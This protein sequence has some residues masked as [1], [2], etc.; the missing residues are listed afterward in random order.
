MM[1]FFP[2]I[3]VNY[4]S[5]RDNLLLDKRLPNPFP[6]RPASA[7]SSNPPL[8]LLGR[9]K[10]RKKLYDIITKAATTD[11]R[12]L[13]II[14]GETGMGKSALTSFIFSEITK[15]TFPSQNQGL[16][17][18]SA[19]IEA[20]GEAN[21]FRLGSFY[22]Q[23]IKSLDKHGQLGTIVAKVI[24][25]IG[26]IIYETDHEEFL[27]L[28]NDWNIN[29]GLDSIFEHI[30]NYSTAAQFY[31]NLLAGVSVFYTQIK[32]EWKSIDSSFLRVL[33]LSQF[34]TKNRLNAIESLITG[35]SFDSFAVSTDAEARDLINTFMD[36]L[37]TLNQNTAFVLF[38]D[39]LEELFTIQTPEKISIQIFTLLLT[40]R[41]IPKLS[42][43]LSGNNQAFKYLLDNLEE[44]PRNQIEQWQIFLYL[45]KLEGS[46]VCSIIYQLLLEFWKAQNMTPD[47]KAPF[48][49]FSEK[50]IE[51]I[52][53]KNDRNLRSTLINFHDIVSKFRDDEKVEDLTD[54]IKAIASL[55][56]IK[57]PRFIP[58]QIQKDFYNYLISNKIQ[59][60][61]RAQ[62]PEDALH[63]LFTLLMRE[64]DYISEV[65]KSPK[66]PNSGKKPDIY[67]R[68]GGNLLHSNST[69]VGIEVKCYRRGNKVDRGNIMK[70]VEL[71]EKGDVDYV[72]WVTNV[73][74][75]L[76]TISQLPPSIK[77]K[78]LSISPKT[79]EQF[80]Y[81]YWTY[82]F[83]DAMNRPP[84]KEE[85]IFLFD[86][87]G[88]PEHLLRI[89]KS[90]EPLVLK[91]N[92]TPIPEPT[93]S[94]HE[95]ITQFLL[96]EFESLL[97]KGRKQVRKE[98]LFTSFKKERIIEDESS[99]ELEFVDIL[100]KIVDKKDKM[101]T[102]TRLVKFIQ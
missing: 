50:T 71:L 61:F 86:K 67:Y 1:N 74:L 66:L 68:L 89:E 62:I 102:T 38:I 69:K 33:L 24:Q 47:H 54:P 60:K 53:E 93:E 5:Q 100:E 90:G 88:Y 37:I 84:S 23:I 6:G 8:K 26:K 80:A 28:F 12:P 29:E 16:D 96:D 65:K 99:V 98:D 7:T 45:P 72:V 34:A 22:T 21:D 20:Y 15:N 79:E 2:N 92:P 9:D 25:K 36:L 42:I 94:F 81:L 14:Q 10:Q 83:Q 76:Q 58:S 57:N 30:N 101:R 40:L 64:V 32:N 19:Y 78:Q 49:P 52:Y 3:S 27:R 4:K 97:S 35:K 11:N 48:Y 95:Q 55:G 13:I 59:D 56:I 39:Q 31:D 43:I 87:I 73:E 41:Q 75:D 70:T 85:V 46:D 51:Y 82:I 63:N 18:Y 44:D 91:P 17:I 77:E